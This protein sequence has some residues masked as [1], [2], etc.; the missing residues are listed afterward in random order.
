LCITPATEEQREA[1]RIAG[2]VREALEGGPDLPLFAQRLSTAGVLMRPV[3]NG[4]LALHGVRFSTRTASFT[5]GAIG[6]TGPALERAGP[7]Y[8][9]A[10]HEALVTRLI[11][12]HDRVMGPVTALK[13]R[14]TAVPARAEPSQTDEARE[15]LR[16]LITEALPGAATVFDLAARLEAV[17]VRT[18]T[19]LDTKRMRVSSVLFVAEGA[20]VP[21]PAVGL[22]PKDQTPDFWSLTAPGPVRMNTDGRAIAPATTRPPAPLP[23]RIGDLL[24]EGVAELISALNSGAI[25]ITPETVLSIKCGSDGWSRLSETALLEIIGEK[26]EVGGVEAEIAP[27][28][29][30]DRTSALRWVCRGLRPDLAYDLHLTRAAVYEARNAER[31]RDATPEP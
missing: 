15:R 16:A 22:G 13:G 18:E 12:E 23:E 1:D 27:L 4:E 28:S 5:G 9:H 26:M 21:G 6:L 25:G 20:R 11:T 19:R 31:T 8:Q 10:E 2:L 29:G 7:K 24:N 3:I 17:G 14:F 30:A